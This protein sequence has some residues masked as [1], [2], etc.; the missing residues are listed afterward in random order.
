[1][2]LVKGEWG[3]FCGG[4][5]SLVHSH[6]ESPGSAQAQLKVFL[7]QHDPQAHLFHELVASPL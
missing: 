2:C 6:L 1:M 4:G 3:T 5:V 7:M